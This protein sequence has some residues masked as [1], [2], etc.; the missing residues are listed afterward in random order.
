[1]READEAEEAEEAD[2]PDEVDEPDEADE[3]DEPEVAGEAEETGE[4][5]EPEEPEEPKR[6]PAM[7]AGEAARIALEQIGMLTSKQA[8][9]ITGIER[10]DGG[11]TVGVELVEDQR[12]PSSADILATYE[13]TIDAD[14]ELVSYRR[15]RRYARGRGDAEES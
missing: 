3:V 14:G 8:E 2:E 7:T 9:G 1:M 15:I 11:W 10:T 6:Q 12:I 5:E 4:T 13:T